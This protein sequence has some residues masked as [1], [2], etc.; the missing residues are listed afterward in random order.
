MT[1]STADRGHRRRTRRLGLL[2]AVAAVGIAG[3]D[4]DG[5]PDT[6]G[7]PSLAS[8][9]GQPYPSAVLTIRHRAPQ[10]DLDNTYTLTCSAADATLD[11]DAVDVDPQ[12]ACEALGDAAVVDWLLDGPPDDQV[13]TEQYG[14][15]D[16]AAIEGTIETA[17]VD[18]TVDRVNGCGISTWDD[19][20]APIL[21]PAV[22]VTDGGG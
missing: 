14:G 6:V 7:R 2:L 8:V 22:G 1:A 4:D 9:A 16:T 21:P 13:C 20:L 19:L 15:D 3:C 10:V 11:G 18:V 5:A 17:P 12:A